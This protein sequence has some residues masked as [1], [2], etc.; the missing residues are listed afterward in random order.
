MK[1]N[2]F[3]ALLPILFGFYGSHAQDALN[4]LANYNAMLYNPARVG[5]TPQYR[6]CVGHR[7][8][9]L[10]LGSPFRSQY[11]A[12]DYSFGTVGS[13]LGVRFQ[14]DQLGRLNQIKAELLY[15]FHWQVSSRLMA[16]GG[17]QLGYWQRNLGI[18]N[19]IFEDQ[20]LNGGSSTEPFIGSNTQ[21]LDLGVGG[22]VYTELFWLGLGLHH[23]NTPN[24]AFVQD[25]EPVR[26]RATLESGGIIELNPQTQAKL[27]AFLSYQYPYWQTLL[28]AELNIAGFLAGLSYKNAL[29]RSLGHSVV[30]H[31][32]FIKESWSMQLAY[33][34]HFE[35]ALGGSVEIG[36][37]YALPYNNRPRK[38]YYDIKCPV[39]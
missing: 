24:L 17:M 23:L 13:G 38:S 31:G 5:I 11:A 18:G 15:G 30:V 21:E 25:M 4:A 14:N 37:F 12:F 6:L 1:K 3:F 16:S 34:W 35:R 33:E 20:I 19:L 36:L 9:W 22:L 10:L 32:G 39:Y 29:P 27:S 28:D 7:S 2:I 26:I 8:Q